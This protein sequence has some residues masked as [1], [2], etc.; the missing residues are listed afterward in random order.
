MATDD[1]YSVFQS[2]YSFI[3]DGIKSSL[4]DLAPKLF[5]RGLID[6]STRQT[7]TS[8]SMPTCD[9]ANAVM[10]SLDAIIRTDPSAVYKLLSV[11]KFYNDEL[12]VLR[13]V[14]SEL[15][16]RLPLPLQERQQ[17]SSHPRVAT[18][19]HSC[20]PTDESAANYVIGTLPPAHLIPTRTQTLLP[21]AAYPVNPPGPPSLDELNG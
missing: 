16:Q 6:R 13:A 21:Q 11:L 10:E 19:A 9:R 7:A 12:P 8:P 1:L 5:E 17:T 4:G 14:A 20:L 15:H 3:L 2:R 18:S